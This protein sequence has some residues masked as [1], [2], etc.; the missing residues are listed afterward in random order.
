MII[1]SDGKVLDWDIFGDT[2][3][4]KM[5]SHMFFDA[6]FIDYPRAVRADVLKQRSA[7]CPRHWYVP[8]VFECIDCKAQFEFSISEQQ[9]WYEELKFFPSVTPIRCAPCRKIERKRRLDKQKPIGQR[10]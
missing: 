5:P 4:R 9:F 1:A 10:E 7:V 3:V 2:D 6:V 8:V